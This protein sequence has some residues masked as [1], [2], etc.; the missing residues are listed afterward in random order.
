MNKFYCSLLTIFTFGIAVQTNAQCTGDRYKEFIFSDV[1]TTNDVMFGSNTS[2]TGGATE[3]LFLDIRQPVGDTET[4]RPVIFFAHGG[5]FV[6]GSK[7]GVDVVPLATDFARMGYVTVSLQYRLG[8]NTL[9]PDSVSA[10]EAVIRGYHDA[11]AAIR[12][13]RKDFAENG[14]TYGIDTAQFFF[15]GVSAGGFITNHLIFL[16]D[17]T[18]FPSYVDYTKPG[19]EGGLEGQSGNAGYSSSITAGINI[20]GAVRDTA[21]MSADDEPLLSF[22][23][24]NDDVVPY[25]HDIVAPFFNLPILWVFGSGPIH[26]HADNIGMDNCFHEYT[27]PPSAAPHV[28]HASDAAHYDTTLVLMRNFLQHYVCNDPLVC[29]YT[30]PLGVGVDE[31][32]TAQLQLDV[33]PNPSNGEVNITLEGFDLGTTQLTITDATGRVAQEFNGLTTSTV[34]LNYGTLSSGIYF[35]TASSGDRR[36]A[37]RLVIQ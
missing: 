22:H 35:V 12:F 30:T 19:L 29:G 31:V 6:G 3:D 28:P 13:M 37:T 34:N 27:N 8:M 36:I 33:Y 15:C 14:N 24:Q 25:G 23:A 18:E 20:C 5:S 26:D 16:D 32:A 7:D 1:S 10:T 17:T 4:S 11:K 9:P 2:W 21:Y